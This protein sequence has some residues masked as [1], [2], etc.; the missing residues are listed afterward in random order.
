[1][2]AENIYYL[3]HSK[4]DKRQWDKCVD[5][6][7]NGLIYAYSFYLDAMADHW[8]AIVLNDYEAVMPLPWRKKYGI[9]YLYQP[10]LIAQLGLFGNGLNAWLLERFFKAIPTK[11]KLWEFPLNQKNLFDVQG[12]NLYQR[13]NFVLDLNR[14]YDALYNAYRENSKRNI[15]KAIGYGCSVQKGIAIDEIIELNKLQSAQ[16]T[17]EKDY[18][19]FQK[20]FYQLREKGKAATY[21]V[22]HNDQLIASCCF[23][24]SHHR[25]YYI[26]VGNHP[27]GRTLGASHLL[28]DAFIKDHAN[29]NLLL[30][31]EG[32]DVRNLA[33]F[34][35]SFGAADEKYAAIKYNNLPWYVKW[36]KR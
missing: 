31:F 17:D 20:L 32:S 16:A 33:F 12:F 26:F 19:R 29:Q 34:Y 36:F 2:A 35:S 7:G 24:F 10:F 25:A 3:P 18:Q 9:Y 28:V 13:T 4:I 1:M 22:Y 15:R 14:N 23:L 11:F 21:G 6:S 8:D 30:D 5:A 27:N